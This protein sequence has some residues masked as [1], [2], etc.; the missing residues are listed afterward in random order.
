[1]NMEGAS[2]FRTGWAGRSVRRKPRAERTA[3]LS[4]LSFLVVTLLSSARAADLTVGWSTVDLTPELAKDRQA[5][6]SGLLIPRFT[7]DV[8]S[9]VSATALALESVEPSGSRAQ[10]VMVSCDAPM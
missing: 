10:A 2:H 6:I 4:W 5:A 9:R 3:H 8:K 7:S 1:M